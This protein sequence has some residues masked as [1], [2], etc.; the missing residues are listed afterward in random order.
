MVDIVK[1]AIVTALNKIIYNV[2]TID[3]YDI[4]IK[5]IKIKNTTLVGV[6]KLVI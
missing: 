2:R 3:E 1:M 6:N 4:I 5:L